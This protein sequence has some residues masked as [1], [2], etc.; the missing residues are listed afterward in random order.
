M[1][2]PRVT[3]SRN[4]DI[5][6][7]QLPIQDSGFCDLEGCQQEQFIPYDVAYKILQDGAERDH[8]PQQ[9]LY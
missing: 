9:S 7:L 2:I 4:L 1:W 8:S 5:L 3:F 6:A